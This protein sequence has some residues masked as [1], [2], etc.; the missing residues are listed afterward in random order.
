MERRL[1]LNRL[2][3]AVAFLLNG[4]AAWA[5]QAIYR[6]CEIQHESTLSFPSGESETMSDQ[7]DVVYKIDLRRRRVLPSTSET[8]WPM[9]VSGRV[10]KITVPD[11]GTPDAYTS[12]L[13]LELEP[14]GRLLS[15]GGGKL[16][17]GEI[18]WFF[19]GQCVEVGASVF[20]EAA[21]P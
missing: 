15:T 10:L 1:M 8:W 3:L 9:D 2:L 4:A 18:H 6:R 20:E 12:K 14:P 13:S 11:L 17:G 19:Q 7:F 5:D 21:N 16:R